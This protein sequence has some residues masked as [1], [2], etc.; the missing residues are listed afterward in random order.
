MGNN[1]RQCF[2]YKLE[3]LPE[4]YVMMDIEKTMTNVMLPLG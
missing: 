2:I 3:I 1:N 4:K